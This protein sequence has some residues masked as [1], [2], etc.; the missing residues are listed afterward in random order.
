[1]AK[2]FPS[3]EWFDE[4]GDRLNAN[5]T[6]TEQAEGWGVDFDGDF[7]FTIEAGDGLPETYHYFIGLEDGDCTGTRPVDN[8]A[9]V[10]NGFELSGPYGNWQ[11]LVRG[12]MG[13][14]EG[15]MGGDFELDGSMNTLLKYQDAATTFV[16]SCS[17]IETEF[18]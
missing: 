7:I 16:E 8:P 2:T 18:A 11:S 15:I 17:E 3:D 10:E 14:I 9:E 5:E 13:A 12:E 4:L 6:Y 1:M